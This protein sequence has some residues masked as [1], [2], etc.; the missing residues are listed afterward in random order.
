MPLEIE[1]DCFAGG[2]GASLGISQATGRSVAIAINHDPKAI[3]M[4]ARNHPETLHF[5]EDV[6]ERWH[7]GFRRRTS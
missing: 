1:V 4:H 7:K 5:T 3:E 6:F 2:G